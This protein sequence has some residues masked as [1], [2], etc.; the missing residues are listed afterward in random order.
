MHRTTPDGYDY[1][2]GIVSR[3]RSQNLHMM[4]DK[5]GPATWYVSQ[6]E[7]DDYDSRRLKHPLSDKIS[8][9]EQSAPGL[10]QARNDILEDAFSRDLPAVMSDDDLNKCRQV[11]HSMPNRYRV[12]HW[13]DVISLMCRRQEDYPK[14]KLSSFRADAQPL[15]FKYIMKNHVKVIASMYLV[16]PSEPR[17]R[18]AYV[19]NEDYDFY[20][21]H[22]REYG[23]IINNYDLILNYRHWGNAGGAVDERM[24]NTAEQTAQAL[25]EQFRKDWPFFVKEDNGRWSSGNEFKIGFKYGEIKRQFID[26]SHIAVN[27][28][29]EINEIQLDMLIELLDRYE[30]VEYKLSSIPEMITEL[31]ELED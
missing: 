3:R 26:K 23:G 2:L 24:S 19:Q 13:D 25:N 11:I 4:S 31:V 17:F 20:L 14:F 1:W 8:V 28:P 12:I 27:W 21:Q 9:V 15:G 29:H 5:L 30:N 16:H 10:P 18:D 6:D 7:V 22:C